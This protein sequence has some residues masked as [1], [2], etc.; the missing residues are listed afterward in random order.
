MHLRRNMISAA[1]RCTPHAHAYPCQPTCPELLRSRCVYSSRGAT[2]PW[3]VERACGST[4]RSICSPR[5]RRLCSPWL[6]GILSIAGR[7]PDARCTH[8]REEK[9]LVTQNVRHTRLVVALACCKTMRSR[10]WDFRVCGNAVN[11]QFQFGDA[12]DSRKL[13]V[14]ARTVGQKSVS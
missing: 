12:L 14:C 7:G 6:Q 8:R 1:V 3:R 4:P 13:V 11:F 9:A 5:R 10:N 2:A